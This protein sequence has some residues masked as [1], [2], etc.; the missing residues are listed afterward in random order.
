MSDV[1]HMKWWGW[2]VPD[3]A[4]TAVDKPKLAPFIFEA[5]SV[6]ITVPA[7]PPPDF[8]SLDVPAT[9]LPDGL[10]AALTAAVGETDVST[11][12]LERVVHT[13][14]KG[15]RDLVRVRSG[16]FPRVPDVVVY[17]GDEDDVVAVTKLAA[18][19]G[20]VLIPFGGGSNIVGALEPLPDESRPIISL[21]MGRMAKVL[22]VDPDSGLARIQAGVLGPD[23]EEQLNA[24]GWTM[25]HFP[26]SFTH[27][28]LGGWIATR[29]S[30]MQSDQYGDIADITRGL[31]LVLPDGE[32]VVL[33]AV[34]STSSGPS[35]REMILGSEGR[36][37]VIT[38]A[39]VNVHRL[40]EVR[41]IQAYF[42]PSYAAGIDAM[43]EVSESDAAPTVTRVSDAQETAFSMATGKKSRGA[44][45]WVTKGLTEYLKRTGWDLGG[46]CLSFVGYEGSPTHVRYEKALVGKI[47][48]RHG[49]IGVGQGPGALYDQ[50]KFDTPYI[51][52][53]L[54]DRG[55]LADVSETASPWSSMLEIHDTVVERFHA[56]RRELGLPGYIMCH[57]SHGYHS[58]SCQYFT[59]AITDSGPDALAHYDAVKRVIQQTFVDLGATVS[60]HHG[61]GEEH[62]PWLE[63][64]ISPGGV[65]LQRVLFSGVDPDQRANPGKIVH[66]GE[67]GISSNSVPPT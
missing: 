17:P 10:A 53:F 28:T 58:G 7:T 38:E 23:M 6:D 66:E 59:F 64:D 27:S 57:L 41:E 9:R 29:S 55:A 19:H 35:V 20:A 15:V 12:D 8:S 46:L 16:Y 67:P 49:G 24:Q 22:S 50:K 44:S 56:K 51:R 39:T 30:G 52:D 37:G 36:L 5:I 4:F 42:F 2:G 40:P 48:K 47:V 1:A 65:R 13:Y 26:D 3:H 14:G 62:S 25:G 54:L 60:H 33:H 31:R 32:L 21:D 63:Q 34:P 45:K 43:R 61:V 11:D 18:E